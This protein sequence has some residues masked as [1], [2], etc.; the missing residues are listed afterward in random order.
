MQSS[1]AIDGIDKLVEIYN[2]GVAEEI[3]RH[4]RS[5]ARLEPADIGSAET[6]D[7]PTY[8]LDTSEVKRAVGNDA[9][10]IISRT[11]AMAKAETFSKTGDVDGALAIVE[12]Y[13]G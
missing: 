3:E 10:G 7:V 4:M 12:K 8:T 13:M 6:P 2:E 5:M 9:A 11:I 1:Q